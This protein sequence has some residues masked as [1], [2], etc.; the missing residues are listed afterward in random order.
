VGC[1]IVVLMPVTRRDLLNGVAAAPAALGLGRLG[2]SSAVAAPESLGVL[3]DY[4][5]G[6]LS[7][8]YGDERPAGR[9]AW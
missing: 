5:A 2:A 6:V 7:A 9:N 8:A 3:L 1:P 4:A